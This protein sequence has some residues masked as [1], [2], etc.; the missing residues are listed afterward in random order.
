MKKHM[1]K[2]I[3]VTYATDVPAPWIVA[4]GRGRVAERM[5]EIA[6]QYGIP[7]V[8]DATLAD[9]LIE[10]DAGDFIPEELYGVIAEVLVFAMRL[11]Q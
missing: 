9:R 7:V 11:S 4:R 10:L 3:A 6:A 8:V 5:K 1:N 2:A